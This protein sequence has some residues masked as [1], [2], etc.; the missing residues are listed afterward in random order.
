MVDQLE[1]ISSV[2]KSVKNTFLCGTFRQKLS[3]EATH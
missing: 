1:V 3:L 2:G